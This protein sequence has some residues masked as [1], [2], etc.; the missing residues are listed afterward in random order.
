MK[1]AFATWNGADRKDVFVDLGRRRE[2]QRRHSRHL[3]VQ[4]PA[5]SNDS[6]N[7]DV[8]HTAGGH[9][10]RA[11]ERADGNLLEGR[12]ASSTNRAWSRRSR[13]S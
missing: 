10:A 12:V 4:V 9:G 6:V 11:A 8:L 5:R 3:T 1:R 13:P 7:D 2:W